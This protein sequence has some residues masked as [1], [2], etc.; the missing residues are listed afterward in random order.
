IENPQ[1]YS[2][3]ALAAMK[4][5]ATDTIASQYQKAGQAVRNQ[6]FVNGGENLPSGVNDMQ[7]EALAGAQASDTAGALENIDVQNETLK[8]QNYWNAV[9]ALSGNAAQFNPNGTAANANGAGNTTANLSQAYKASTSSQLLGALGGIAGG[10][11]TALAGYFK[12]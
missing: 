11:G 9:N 10:A 3:D 2:P 12:G 7:D 1:G 6:R 4:T 8:Q 5:N